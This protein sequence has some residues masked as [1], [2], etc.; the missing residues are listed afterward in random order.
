MFLVK[1]YIYQIRCKPTDRRYVGSSSSFPSYQWAGHWSNLRHQRHVNQRFQQEWNAYPSLV[2]WEF[3][4]LEVI[5]KRLDRRILQQVEAKYITTKED[6]LRLNMPNRTTLSLEKH[7]RVEEML[8]AG[9]RYVDIRDEVGIS[10]GMISKIRKRME[11]E[12]R[13]P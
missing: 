9:A 2:H 7:R 13:T 5:D 4:I 3:T 12:V 8:R 11:H 6:V 1:H 10:T